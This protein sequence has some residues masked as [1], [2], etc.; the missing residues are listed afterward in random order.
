MGADRL[1]VQSGLHAL[2]GDC[3]V[4]WVS[5]TYVCAK[6]ASWPQESS[7]I[8]S[9]FLKWSY[10]FHLTGL[11][12]VLAVDLFDRFLLTARLLYLFLPSIM[13]SVINLSYWPKQ[14]CTIYL[15]VCGCAC[16]AW[17]CVRV[18]V[19]VCVSVS[20]L[21]LS[22]SVFLSTP[23]PSLSLSLSLCASLP[24][25]LPL[26]LPHAVSHPITYSGRNR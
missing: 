5:V 26:C 21:C 13:S 25:C 23:S 24:P 11:S 3:G 10:R 14:C 7:A 6:K 22:L 18:R 9:E 4:W 15:C 16:G 19:C 12:L 2:C 8:Q 17:G 1:F 20:F